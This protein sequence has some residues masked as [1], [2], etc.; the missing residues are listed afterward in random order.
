M[1]AC[2]NGQKDVI[3]LL[4]EHSNTKGIDVSTDELFNLSK[5]IAI[6]ILTCSVNCRLSSL[7]LQ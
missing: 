2:A 5:E 6:F 4:F 7:A 3:K 1:W